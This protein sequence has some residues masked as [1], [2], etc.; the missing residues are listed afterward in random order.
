MWAPSAHNRQ[1]WRFAVLTNL[2]DKERLA[3]AMGQ[4]LR[5]DRTNDGD[6][7]ELI[8]KDVMRSFSRLTQAPTLIILCLSME[9]MDQYPDRRRTEAE[10]TMA[11]QSVAMAAQNLWLS[12]HAHGLGCCWICAPLFVPNLVKETCQLPTDWEPLGIL[13]L[14]YP[15][16][17]REKER[18]DWQSKVVFK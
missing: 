10:R 4:R 6:D 11:I 18:H 5:Q 3:R 9:D 13:T 8:E 1:P 17:K 15:A 7:P 16:Q 2:A 12:A 14:G